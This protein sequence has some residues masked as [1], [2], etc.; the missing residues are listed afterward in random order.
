M[1]SYPLICR[2]VGFWHRHSLQYHKKKDETLYIQE[3]K[4][5]T[6]FEVS[7]GQMIRT[8]ALPGD[9]FGVPPI[10]RHRI[11]ALEDTT[12]FEVSN[13]ELND[14]ESIEYGYGRAEP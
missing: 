9:C 14:V 10:T 5:V 4:A 8:E 11:E 6:E 2:R 3:G 13:P 1:G 7:D 12:L